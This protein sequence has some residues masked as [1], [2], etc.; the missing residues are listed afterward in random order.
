[1]TDDQ[2]EESY[3]DLQKTLHGLFGNI[4]IKSDIQGHIVAKGVGA[5]KQFIAKIGITRGAL[6]AKSTIECWEDKLDVLSLARPEFK[7]AIDS[8]KY[9]KYVNPP[10]LSFII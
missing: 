6:R 4:E 9:F 1:M 8:L 7:R 3:I 10:S 5:I 2:I